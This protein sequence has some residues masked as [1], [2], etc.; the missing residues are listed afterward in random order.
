MAAEASWTNHEEDMLPGQL[1]TQKHDMIFYYWKY[2][3]W[4]PSKTSKTKFHF[5]A[6]VVTTTNNS[7]IK[8]P[9]ESSASSP[10]VI[11]SRQGQH[12]WICQSHLWRSQPVSGAT[13]TK[14]GTISQIQKPK[15]LPRFLRFETPW[16]PR[17]PFAPLLQTA[18][19]P[20]CA[21][22]KHTRKLNHKINL[23]YAKLNKF[24]PS[25]PLR[26]S[27]SQCCPHRH[28]NCQPE[29]RSTPFHAFQKEVLIVSDNIVPRATGMRQLYHCTKYFSKINCIASY[30][31][32]CICIYIYINT[33]YDL[34]FDLDPA[35]STKKSCT[36]DINDFLK[37]KT[38]FVFALANSK[39]SN[40]SIKTCKFT[41]PWWKRTC[42]SGTETMIL[43]ATLWSWTNSNKL[44]SCARLTD[45]PI[46]PTYQNRHKFSATVS[47]LIGAKA[48]RDVALYAAKLDKMAG[49]ILRQ[50][51]TKCECGIQSHRKWRR[52][53]SFVWG[54]LVPKADSKNTGDP[55]F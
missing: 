1:H 37:E 23:K 39:R 13:I 28:E 40:Q 53:I 27:S 8:S 5:P 3:C 36:L 20:R 51:Q 21:Y 11:Q 55:I 34:A 30:N 46:Q 49:G 2:K 10:E 12:L 42:F 4:C 16:S 9:S 45:I 38:Y 7:A 26:W 18:C 24:W 35:S 19:A 52:V 43:E 14:I 17:G 54:T 32:K 44:N 31:K 50:L 41:T 48:N 15:G 22:A 29:M 33:V 6:W 47:V 25:N